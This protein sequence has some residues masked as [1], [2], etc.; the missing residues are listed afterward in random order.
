MARWTLL[1]IMVL[2]IV[3]ASAFGCGEDEENT[4]TTACA[5]ASQEE[6]VSEESGSGYGACV[7][8]VDSCAE[9]TAE[10]SCATYLDQE[11]CEAACT[12]DGTACTGTES[13][14][15]LPCS[16]YT[17][18]VACEIPC[19]WLVG[20]CKVDPCADKLEADCATTDSQNGYGK[21]LW[22]EDS[23]AAPTAETSCG[24]YLDQESC[25]GAC[26]WD[27]TA[28]TG[29]ESPSGL[30]CSN[31][32]TQVACEIPCGWDSAACVLAD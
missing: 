22:A 24:T 4:Q 13:P 12:W 30:P 26:T 23:C 21:C 19:G 7:W 5:G 6:C 3:A 28:C 1:A 32:T 9:P 11:S 16:N 29:T 18:Q 31:Y 17:T 20:A 27:G 2:S 8:A 25:E 15:G 14:S 10:T